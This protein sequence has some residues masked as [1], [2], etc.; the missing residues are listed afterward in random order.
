MVGGGWGLWGLWGVLGS[1]LPCIRFIRFGEA[2]DKEWGLES[3]IGEG[4]GSSLYIPAQVLAQD[5]RK[6]HCVMAASSQ[7]ALFLDAVV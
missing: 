2:E 5:V 7:V 6:S 3:H 4:G 1:P